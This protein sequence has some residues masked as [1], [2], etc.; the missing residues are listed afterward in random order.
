[1]DFFPIQATKIAHAKNAHSTKRGPGRYHSSGL[2]KVNAAR[3]RPSGLGDFGIALRN[4]QTARN[5]AAIK[6]KQ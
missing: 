1:M 5:L 4:V 6:A 2:R 3:W